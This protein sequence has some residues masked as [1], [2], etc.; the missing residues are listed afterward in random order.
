MPSIRPAEGVIID[1]FRLERR[2]HNG[3]MSSLWLVS[4]DGDP[5]PMVMKLPSLAEGEDVSAIVGFEVERMI[6]P[7]LTG[8]HVPRFVAA[9]DLSRTP[10]LVMEKVEGQNLAEIADAAPLPPERVAELGAR[11]ARGLQELHRQRVLHLDLKPANIMIG[12]GGD[13]VFLDFGLSRHDELPDLLGEESDVPMG[14]G[15]YIAPEQ[16][17]GDRTE[18]RSD[19]FA[20]GVI[21]YELVTG[22]LPFGNPQRKA[23]MKRRLW[24]DPTPPRKLNPACPDWLQEI[25]LRCLEVDPYQRYATPAQV[26]FALQHPDQVTVTERGKRW[27]ADGPLTV[28]RRWLRSGNPRWERK[29]PIS[30]QVVGA[31]IV[32][33]A[34]DLGNGVDALG[35]LLRIHAR[36]ALDVDP[37]SRLA[38]VTILKTALLQVESGVDAQGNNLYVQRL[39]ALKDWARPI[40]LDDERV[41]VHVLEA[42]DA[43]AALIEYARKNQVDH[44]VMGARANSALRRYLGSVS[45]QVVAEAPCTVTVVRLAQP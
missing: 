1:G 12:P 2:I 11:I 6:L 4:R 29:P 31:P 10:Y 16:I 34:V 39:I 13:A 33:A 45:A 41:S 9:A 20:L 35:E 7:R 38:C 24:K 30:E 14:T 44:I 22:R 42:V 25:V 36:R 37:Q 19:V 27:R 23:G 8:A 28:L 18:P 21:L 26:A 17:E 40:G 5:T 43:A 32:M 3:P 15:A